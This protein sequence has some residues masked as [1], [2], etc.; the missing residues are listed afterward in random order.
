MERWFVTKNSNVEVKVKDIKSVKTTKKLS[1]LRQLQ[2]AC[3]SYL[4]SKKEARALVKG[5]LFL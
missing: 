5:L 4:V 2:K 3:A 1:E